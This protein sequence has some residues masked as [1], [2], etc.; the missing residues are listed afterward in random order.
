MKNFEIYKD[1]KGEFRF[2]LRASNQ[3]RDIVLKSQAYAS[4]QG[5]KKGVETVVKAAKDKANF[6]QKSTS[7]NRYYFNIKAENG[8]VIATS[9]LY[10]SL[11]GRA[12]AMKVAKNHAESYNV[13]KLEYV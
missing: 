9:N 8:K 10:H 2:R 11:G 1:S 13:A 12:L 3:Y 5:A 7:D 6:E 4:R